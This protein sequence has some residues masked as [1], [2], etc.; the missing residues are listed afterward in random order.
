MSRGDIDWLAR[1]FEQHKLH[2]QHSSPPLRL[3]A[4]VWT[5]VAGVLVI[6]LLV[7][8]TYALW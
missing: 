2:N 7:L 3:P 8:I 4:A 1:R 6:Y 5:V